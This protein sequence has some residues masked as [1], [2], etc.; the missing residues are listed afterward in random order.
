MLNY[1]AYG[2][3]ALGLI[4][5]FI[6]S[7]ET[8]RGIGD[9]PSFLFIVQF[10][11]SYVLLGLLILGEL[12]KPTSILLCFPLLMSRTGR[13]AI[14][15]MIALPV[16]NF[17]EMWTAIIAIIAASIGFF[18]MYIGYHD[19]PVELKFA[20]EGVPENNANSRAT[21]APPPSAKA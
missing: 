9:T 18:N 13:G 7:G 1:C 12:H 6:V 11:L 17:N 16:T 20:E 21:G 4:L 19:G 5:R 3:I 10:L 8:D 14:I 2:L 15:F